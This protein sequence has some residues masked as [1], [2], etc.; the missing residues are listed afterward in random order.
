MPSTLRRAVFAGSWYPHRASEC[1]AQIK[2]FIEQGPPAPAAVPQPVGG[3]VPH[4]GWYYSGAIACNVIRCLT[5]AA[6]PA[7]DVIVVFGMHLHVASAN[8]MMPKGAWETPFGEL[9]V[10][11]ELAAEMIQRVA[12]RLETPD[13]AAP[14]NTVEVQLPFIKYFFPHAT[15]LAMG[16]APTDAA[17]AI[18]KAV[19]EI[20]RR[21][22]LTLKVI[23]S[24]D[25]THYGSNY[26]FT[27]HGSGA[28]A[29]SWV[30]QEN[31]R[32]ILEAMLALDARGVISEALENQNA[33]C[34]GAAAAAIAAG[35]HLGAKRA[36]SIGYATSYDRSPAESFVGY[37]GIV[38]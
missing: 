36:A 25:L 16:V 38:F 9:P 33:C 4:A 32:R 30:T 12:F 28:S 27:G 35:N 11:E 23:G 13:R 3:V 14:D 31:D 19:V 7:P 18:G 37:A 5:Q 8:I 2:T 1:E 34:P 20:S 26:G 22:G 24:T 10:A 6:V 15:I 29:L 17:L 21:L